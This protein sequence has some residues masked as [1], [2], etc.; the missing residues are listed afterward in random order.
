MAEMFNFESQTDYRD[1]V[2]DKAN[3][4]LDM[5]RIYHHRDD[6]KGLIVDLEMSIRAKQWLW[7][8]FS[9]CEGW[10][11]K[12]QIV[13]PVAFTR[14]ISE[15][16]IDRFCRF[17]SDYTE[18]ILQDITTEYGTIREMIRLKDE[19][20]TYL[21]FPVAVGLGY[22]DVTIKG[23]DLNYYDEKRRIIRDKILDLRNSNEHEYY[24]G[25]IVT[26][27]SYAAFKK[28]KEIMS[29]I[30]VNPVQYIHDEDVLKKVSE[31]F[32]LRLN[33]GVKTSRVVNKMLKA[34]KLYSILVGDEETEHLFNSAYAR[35][36]D[37]INPLTIKKWTVISINFVDYLS[38]SYG[39]RWTS[40]LNPDKM[41]YF[42]EGMWSNGFNSRRTLDYALDPSTIVFYTLDS[43]Y[44]GNEYELQPKET[45]Q[46]FHFNGNTLIQSRL[47]PQGDDAR[48]GIYPQHREIIERCIC[49]G[50][51]VP[52]LWTSPRKGTIDYYDGIAKVP[53]EERG[54]GSYIDFF[55]FACHGYD[56][57]EFQDHVNY[58]CLKGTEQTPVM[59]GF[60]DAVDIIT[61]EK[62]R[63]YYTS[64]IT[65]HYCK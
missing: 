33:A 57:Q 43:K 27:D 41:A 40:C 21:R 49:E 38:M 56:E 55:D 11:G 17:L 3:D 8:I 29:F 58:V 2:L 13:L 30:S 64:G 48:A 34:S 42:T 26:K 23:K 18:E 25:R 60:T 36:C 61:G 50:M 65:E 52:N 59:V 7:N 35:Y 10:N 5:C 32:N 19:I 51:G 14:D 4:F 24:L 12:G 20:D 15:G 9:Q 45:R 28:A 46:L 54:C 22:N 47:Y 6:R 39:Y 37:A 31:S 53:Y 62:L 44:E 16:E 63:E 1:Y